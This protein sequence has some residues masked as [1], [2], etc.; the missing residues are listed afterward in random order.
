M[1]N[2]VQNDALSKRLAAVH[3]ARIAV[4]CIFRKGPNMLQVVFVK[5]GDRY[6]SDWVNRHVRAIRRHATGDVKFVCVTEERDETLDPE[7]RWH[8]FPQFVSPYEY[9]LRNTRLKMSIFAPGVLEAEHPALYLDLDSSVVGDVTRMEKHIAE[10]PDGLHMLHGHFLPWL[11]VQRRF[12]YLLGDKYYHANGS[13]IG[14]VPQ[15][16]THV[17][18]LFN[19]LIVGV[20]GDHLPKSHYADDRFLSCFCRESIRVFPTSL[21]VKYSHEYMAPLGIIERVRSRLP[22]VKTRRENLV[23]VS[24]PGK[25]LKPD[26]LAKLEPGTEIRHKWLRGYW[27]QEAQ[28]DYWREA[29]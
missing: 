15:N 19:E 20:E 7:V 21:M 10:D 9:M 14:F 6:G 29:A 18:P 4:A 12:G 3:D 28:V 27:D 22:W 23:A 5:W 11:P 2:A 26:D 1:W 13:A 8:S 24:F 16:F 17:F 25:E